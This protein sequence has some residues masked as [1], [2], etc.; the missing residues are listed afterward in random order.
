M[1]K[2]LIRG[3]APLEGEIAAGGAKNSALPALAACLLTGEPVT[4]RH[5]PRVRD[6]RTMERLLEHA[7]A[8]VEH[9]EAG[10][11][12]IFVQNTGADINPLPRHSEEL[13]V[14]YGNILAAAVQGVVRGRMRPLEGPFRAVLE[15]VNLPFAP[16]PTR[17]ELLERIKST[18]DRERRHAGRLLEIL[19]RDGRIR[20]TYPYPV[21]VWSFGPKLTFIAL[22]SE[23]VVDYALRFKAQYGWDNTW[24]SGY[25]NDLFGYVPS[26]RVLKEGGY[27]GSEAMRNASMPGPFAPD[28][29]EIIAKKVDELVKR[30]T[31]N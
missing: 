6:V 8:A 4:L 27:E 3:G 14:A 17:Q 19:N 29:E 25:N 5:I 15:D 2:F 1:E 9:G 28:V 23:V 22:A 26:L 24:V 18:N 20:D 10:V 7:G 16:P 31:G 11:V 30:T 12:A 21:Q 13:G